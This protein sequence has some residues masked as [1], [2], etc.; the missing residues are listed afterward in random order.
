MKRERREKL[1]RKEWE[2]ITSRRSVVR[3]IPAPEKK[4]HSPGPDTPD[5]GNRQDR[6]EGAS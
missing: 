4:P 3:K 2:E 5:R 1:T 6:G